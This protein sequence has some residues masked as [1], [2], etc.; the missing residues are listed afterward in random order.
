MEPLGQQFYVNEPSHRTITSKVRAKPAGDLVIS[1]LVS[2]VEIVQICHT[3]WECAI[4]PQ[5]SPKNTIMAAVEA[6]AGFR[7][8]A[9]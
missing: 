2:S 5:C 1:N 8:G 7:V 3:R 9:V 6:Y 4:V